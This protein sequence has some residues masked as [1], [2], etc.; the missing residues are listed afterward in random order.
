[1]ATFDFMAVDVSHTLVTISNYVVIVPSIDHVDLED[2]VG[3][4]AVHK[5]ATI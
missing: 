1:M 3:S 2:G 4:L 5:I